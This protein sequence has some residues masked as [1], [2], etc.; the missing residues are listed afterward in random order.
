MKKLLTSIALLAAVAAP[1]N[2]QIW[3]NT[4]FDTDT[5][6][7]TERNVRQGAGSIGMSSY[8]VYVRN[9]CPTNVDIDLTLLYYDVYGNWK[10]INTFLDLSN[11]TYF[12]FATK[13]RR[14]WYYAESDDGK[15][16]WGSSSNERE[17]RMGEYYEEYTLNLTCS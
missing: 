17:K 9:E 6:A 11:K 1:A 16:Y 2:A 7:D 13:N 12:A 10:E 14:F 3:K 5:W 4:P 8:E 15:R